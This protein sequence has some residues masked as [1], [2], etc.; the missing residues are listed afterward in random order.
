M[1]A[2]A[3]E[4]ADP[5]ARCD[6]R[7]LGGPVRDMNLMVDREE[8]R[9]TV[10]V[11]R[12]RQPFERRLAGDWTLVHVISGGARARLAEAQ[13]PLSTGDLLRIDGASD[14]VLSLDCDGPDPALAI[15]EVQRQ[16]R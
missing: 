4:S 5:G 3:C 10:E 9:G 8:A 6:C 12:M 7:L 13:Y 1:S 2:F 11:V 14:E 16:R 15:V